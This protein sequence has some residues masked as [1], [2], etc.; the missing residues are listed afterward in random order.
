M[1]QGSKGLP[2]GRQGT[3]APAS[4]SSAHPCRFWQGTKVM[5]QPLGAAQY[6]VVLQAPWVAGEAAVTE[7]RFLPVTLPAL[8]G[9]VGLLLP[10]PLC[11]LLVLRP[12]P[13]QVPAA[14]LPIQAG[15]REVSVKKLH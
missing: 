1:G 12:D 6:L 2:E 3:S 10:Q 7:L 4:P 15:V 8:P 14:L 5:P 11:K 13:H 9:I